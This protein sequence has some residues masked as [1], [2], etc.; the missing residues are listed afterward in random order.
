MNRIMLNLH[1]HVNKLK[2]PIDSSGHVEL[3]KGPVDVF[4]SRRASP[5][6]D[7]A[8]T[9]T[10]LTWGNMPSDPDKYQYGRFRH[11]I[12]FLNYLAG[13]DLQ[14]TVFIDKVNENGTTLVISRKPYSLYR[15]AKDLNEL[16]DL[17]RITFV[18]KKAPKPKLGSVEYR[19]WKV[20]SLM[21]ENYGEVIGYQF[22]NHEMVPTRG[23]R[24]L[25]RMH[26]R[27]C[28]ASQR[29]PNKGLTDLYN[30]FTNYAKI[31]VD[32]VFAVQ[33]EAGL[34][35]VKGRKRV[36][37]KNHVYEEVA[38]LDYQELLRHARGRRSF[39]DEKKP[40][41][42]MLSKRHIFTFKE[43]IE[44]TR[45]VRFFRV[46]EYALS[47]FRLNNLAEDEQW[48]H[49]Y[50]YQIIDV[51][52]T[53]HNNIRARRYE[54]SYS[55]RWSFWLALQSIMK[56]HRLEPLDPRFLKRRLPLY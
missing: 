29:F 35:N 41:I 3:M 48:S 15:P 52:T 30:C 14:S 39:L 42:D 40:E 37:M 51:P 13:L 9:Y 8:V 21:Q 44:Y 10:I 56:Q 18:P 12:G 23:S 47:R 49:E 26:T 1:D 55:K 6:E 36:E 45:L 4:M 34:F 32:Q 31:F 19:D 2:H 54:Y 11:C 17:K 24:Y 50:Y 25:N 46:G 33:T 22:P 20:Y 43:L 53:F 16:D 38:L 5:D 28:D 27:M 7:G